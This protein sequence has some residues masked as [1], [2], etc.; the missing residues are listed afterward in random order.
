[1]SLPKKGARRRRSRGRGQRTPKKKR[2]VIITWRRGRG[3]VQTTVYE[4]EY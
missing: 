2:T 1:M 4:E 3:P